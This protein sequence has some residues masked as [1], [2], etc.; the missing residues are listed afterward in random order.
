MSQTTMLLR[1]ACESDAPALNK[2]HA[3]YVRHTVITF[4][5]TPLSDP[6]FLSKYRSIRYAGLPY[7]VAVNASAPNP[8]HLVGYIYVSPFRGTHLGAYRHTVELTLYCDPNYTGKGVGT[9]LLERL[10]D[11]LRQ[12]EEWEEEWIGKEWS[13][14]DGR[15]PEVIGVVAVDDESDWK[16]GLG[17]ME[18]YGQFRFE[19]VG[20]L[21]Q[22]G[23]KFGR[24]IDTVYLQLSLAPMA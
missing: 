7:I 23:T 3:H 18:W 9:A 6:A 24:W 2:I 21:K 1:P 12:P 17:L 19:K 13:R 11:I 20:R 8:E 16:G 10:L 22:V 15:V 4:S 14:E 5:V